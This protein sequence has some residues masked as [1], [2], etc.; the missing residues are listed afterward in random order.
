M[1]SRTSW[2][3][4]GTYGGAGERPGRPR[5]RSRHLPFTC[6][7]PRCGR[8]PPA[9]GRAGA[10]AAHPG[11]H[12]PRHRRAGRR[13][14][15]GRRRQRRAH[16]RRARGGRRRARRRAQRA[17]RRRAATRSASGSAAAPPTSTSRSSASCWPGRPTCPVDVDDPDERARLV[18]D[19]ADVAAI[20]GNDQT[21][22][23]RRE[24]PPR[25]PEEPDLGDD[26]W[27]IFTSG[28]TGTPKGV[29]VT[30]RSAAAFVDAESRMFLQA[31]PLGRRR[32]GD[33]RAVGRLR[34]ELRGDVAGLAVRRLP[35][36]RAARAGQE[37][38]RRRPV[39]GRQRRHRRLDRARRWSR[40]GRR[41][42]WPTSGC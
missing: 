6:D 24:G 30:H 34:R 21:V 27:V 26:A 42:R 31:E 41:S 20:V 14:A 4:A 12:L 29:A 2:I 38:H 33:G 39:A 36:P 37:R 11:R 28:S 9:P 10:A 35:G 23:M 22:V 5:R 32:P 40:C 19:E 1:Y 13:R 16:L 25:E 17:R 8:G 3:T 15:G 7:R 18:F